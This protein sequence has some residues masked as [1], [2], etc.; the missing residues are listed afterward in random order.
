M[1]KK[2]VSKQVFEMFQTAREVYPGVLS[3]RHVSKARRLAMSVQYRLPSELRR[4]YCHK[5]Y[6][7]LMPSHN[8]TVR[9]VKGWIH[10]IC[11][12]CNHVNKYKL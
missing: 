11:K 3:H 8:C 5:C 6:H 12:D 7:F 9:T 4:Q 1:K 2:D 10:Y